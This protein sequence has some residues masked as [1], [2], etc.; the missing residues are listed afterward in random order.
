MK[1]APLLAL[2]LALALG[3][4]A[5]AADAASPV[6]FAEAH[7][8]FYGNNHAA[9]EGHVMKIETE[10][11][12]REYFG[13]AAVMGEGGLP[14]AIDFEKQ[15]AAAIILPVTDYDTEITDVAFA[16]KDGKLVASYKVKKGVKRGFF[17]C[18]MRLF[19][20]ERSR[21]GLELVGNPL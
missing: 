21:A 4:P 5:L 15:F 9:P 12:L 3:E 6:P 7:R 18:P 20:L 11:Q 13:M 19:V 16:E 10:A 8:Y 1:A 17:I 2:S 14:T